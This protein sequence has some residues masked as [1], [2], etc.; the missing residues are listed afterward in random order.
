MESTGI[1]PVVS[2]DKRY[3]EIEL[4]KPTLALVVANLQHFAEHYD[5]WGFIDKTATHVTHSDLEYTAGKL[6]SFADS[7]QDVVRVRLDYEDWCKY[8]DSLYYAAYVALD[9]HSADVLE[10]LYGLCSEMEDNGLAPRG[11]SSAS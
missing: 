10:N 11:P 1:S 8:T 7:A 6:R 2:S 3:V 4:D 5:D 9:V